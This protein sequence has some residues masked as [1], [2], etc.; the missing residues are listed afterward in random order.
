MHHFHATQIMLNEIKD[1]TQYES[2]KHRR[3]F[4]DDYF[5]LYTWESYNGD[6]ICSAYAQRA[7]VTCATPRARLGA[8]RAA[9]HRSIRS[10]AWV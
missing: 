6:L 7:V 8:E 2:A 3:W 1:V 5:D 4:H 10:N 9:M